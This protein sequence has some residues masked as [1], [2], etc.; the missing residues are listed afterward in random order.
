MDEEEEVVVEEVADAVEDESLVA[1]AIG[2]S[3][4]GASVGVSVATS[5]IAIT[6][7]VATL[8]DP[9]FEADVG[10]GVEKHWAVQ[11]LS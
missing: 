2:L 1:V 4:V 9:L 10:F 3:S 6:D 5:P 7:E 8:L 11:P